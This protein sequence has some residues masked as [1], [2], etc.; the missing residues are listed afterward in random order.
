[1]GD[2]GMKNDGSVT[3]PFGTIVLYRHLPCG[4]TMSELWGVAEDTLYC[5]SCKLAVKIGDPSA[6]PIWRSPLPEPRPPHD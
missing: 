6:T 1:M 4:N 2:S 3:Q 5:M